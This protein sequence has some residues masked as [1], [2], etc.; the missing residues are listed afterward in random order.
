MRALAALFGGVGQRAGYL[1]RSRQF[2]R[3]ERD[4]EGRIAKGHGAVH[5]E[6]GRARLA[7]HRFHLPGVRGGIAIVQRQA[8][9]ELFV[10]GYA[11]FNGL[12]GYPHTGWSSSNSLGTPRGAVC[13]GMVKGRVW[14]SLGLANGSPRSSWPLRI[15][16]NRVFGSLSS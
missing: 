16:R 9:V 5:L 2:H 12:R 15:R 8:G 3:A 1:A 11:D 4:A 6:G 10:F 13:F 14:N 7:A